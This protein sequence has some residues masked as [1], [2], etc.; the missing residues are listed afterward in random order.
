MYINLTAT[1]T[2]LVLSVIAFGNERI[3]SPIKIK[4]GEY[5]LILG[6]ESGKCKI[7]YLGLKNNGEVLLGITAP[8]QIIR[9]HQHKPLLYTY[10][11][12]GNVSVILI[13]GGPPSQTKK[14][15]FM[16]EGCGTQVQ[17]LLVRENDISLAEEIGK[18]G[19]F[20]PSAGADEKMFWFLSH[21]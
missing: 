10:K 18:G 11:D 5:N 1:L 17:A 3:Q 12:L 13:V 20:C 15:S 8:C 19:T 4:V 2:L 21:K 14:D 7:T 16:K 6:E 9:D